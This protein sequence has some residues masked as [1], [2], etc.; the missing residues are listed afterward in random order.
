MEMRAVGIE[1]E[2]GYV[3]TARGRLM[4]AAAKAAGPRRP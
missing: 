3:G 4:A 1:R 2:A